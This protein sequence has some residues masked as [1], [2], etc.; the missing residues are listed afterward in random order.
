[1][2]GVVANVH[3]SSVEEN[4]SP[5]I[6]VPITQ[7]DPEGANLV[8]RSALP[9]GVLLPSVMS[10]LRSIN[11]GQPAVDFRPIQAIVDHSTSPRRFFVILVALFAALGLILASLG[12][13]GVSSFSVTRQTQEIGIRMALG[14]TRE[15]VQLDV[16]YKTLRIVLI[17]IALGTIVSFA[18][19][20][21]ISSMLFGTAPTDPVTFTVVALL[22]TPWPSR[23]ATSKSSGEHSGHTVV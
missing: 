22:L 18:V 10:T 4:P 21:A 17:G 3:E 1:M 2:V 23:P 6:Y 15:R 5:E 8:I 13:Y 9:L 19:A 12:I 7:D 16:I 14:A 20:R 11:P